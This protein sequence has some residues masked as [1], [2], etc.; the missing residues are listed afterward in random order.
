LRYLLRWPNRSWKIAAQQWL[1]KPS[2]LRE[3]TAAD[4]DG[5]F[6]RVFYDFRIEFE[7]SRLFAGLSTQYFL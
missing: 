2:K 4:L 5:N 3:F 6:I 1:F 7:N